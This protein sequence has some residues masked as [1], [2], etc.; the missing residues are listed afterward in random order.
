MTDPV[1]KTIEVP[2]SAAK[3]FD[4]F[5]SQTSNWWPLDKHSVS[6]GGGKQA[7]AI[8]IE[9]KPGGA[10]F[11]TMQDGSRSDWGEVLEIEPGQR[12]SL[13]WNPGMSAAA[14]TRVDVSFKDLPGGRARVTLTHSGWEALADKAD[15]MRNGYN[16]GWVRVFEERFA[17][18][19]AG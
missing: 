15:E 4:V 10:V 16:E 7:Q 3:A 9:A 8:T 12:L 5:V 6:A 11:E 14:M 18:G 2:C 17:A 13:S 1:I 19:C